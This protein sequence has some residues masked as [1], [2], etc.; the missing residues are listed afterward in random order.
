MNLLYISPTFHPFAG[1]AESLLDDLTRLM[2]ARGHDVTVITG[3][4][5]TADVDA[6]R[7]GVR[8][9]RVDYPVL[10][11][12]VLGWLPTLAR[13]AALWWRHLRVIRRGKVDAVGIGLYNQ[14]ALYVFLTAPFVRFRLVIYLHGG[15][16]RHLRRKSRLFRWVYSYGLSRCDAV[17]AVS[18]DL[19][20]EVTA[21]APWVEP[22]V[23]VIPNGVIPW[24]VRQQAAAGPPGRFLLFAGRLEPVKN[25]DLLMRAFSSAA[26]AVSDVSLVI[27]GT[28]SREADLKKLARSLAVEDRVIFTGPVGRETVYGFLKRAELVVLPSLAEGHPLILIEAIVAGRWVL[29]SDVKGNRDLIEPGRNGSLFPSND[30]ERLARLIVEFTSEHALHGAPDERDDPPDL[31]RFDLTKLVEKHIEVLMGK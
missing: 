8:V 24:A 1:G 23:V 15:E 26:G 13:Q 17:I 22:K 28:G 5:A 12:G 18:Q 10:D 11:S 30:Q 7:Q 14:T 16:T 29:A 2:V 6:A 20:A 21:L 9:I 19:K 27:A 4:P 25:V 31:A 3:T